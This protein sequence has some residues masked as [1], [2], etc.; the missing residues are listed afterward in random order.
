MKNQQ[1]KQLLDS[2]SLEE[3]I[4]QLVQLSG[5][6]YQAKSITTGPKQRLGITQKMVDLSGSVLNVTGAEQVK[7]VQEDHLKK[8]EH[9]IP[10]LFMADIV[11]GYRTIYPIPLGIGATWDFKLVEKAYCNTADE[12]S[13]SGADVTFAPMLDLVRD[14]RWGRVLESTGEDPVLNSCFARAMVKG[15]QKNLSNSNGLVACIKHFAGYGAVEAGREYNSVDLSLAN[16]KQ[17]YLPSYRSAVNAG[18]KMVMSSL[19]TLNGVPSTGDRWLLNDVL[20]KD[21]G[22]DGVII[23]DYA[24]IQELVNHGFASDNDDAARLAI[25]AGVDIDMK[26][27][28]YANGLSRLLDKGKINEEKINMAVWRVLRLKNDLGLFEDPFRGASAKRENNSLLSADKRSVARK[29]S[30]ESIV[31]LKNKDKVLPLSKSGKKKIAV[32]GPY[33]D[34]KDLIGLWALHA[35]SNDT[36]TLADGI[37]EKLSNSNYTIAK[38]TDILRDR[39]L[40]EK[41]GTPEESTKQLI[42]D[43]TSE[44]KQ[45][46]KALSDASKSDI[47]IFACGEHPIQS[48]EAGSRAL[49]RLPINQIKLFNKLIK[50]GKPIITIIFSGRPLVLTDIVSKSDGVLQAWFPG[51]EG[52]HALGDILFGDYNPSGH[53]SMGIPYIEGQLP[54]HYDHLSTGRAEETSSHHSRFVS[55]YID[56]PTQPLFPFGFGLSYGKMLYEKLEVEQSKVQLKQSVNCRVTLNNIGDWA[57]DEVVQIYFHDDVAS[58]V[59]P[60]KRL[61]DFKRVHVKSGEKIQVHFSIPIEKFG[62]YNREG[63]YKLEPGVFTL[64]AGSDSSTKLSEKFELI[65]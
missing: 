11:Y 46:Q 23:S 13:S 20:R 21:W 33:A 55:R 48:S 28:C 47:I 7:R 49:L 64:F 42:S 17:N 19:T 2:L 29:L 60:V 15:L 6:F 25:N 3:K 24:S 8:G 45:Q 62:F 34:N 63:N 36:V 61:I 26:S 32:I 30:R 40:F 1:L 31:L 59:Q 52:G 9:P 44:I 4:G 41:F 35:N 51:T 39:K 56:V 65:I 12:A 50:L 22:F 43:D 57:R 58:V 14:P 54:M 37:S 10:L 53:L 18:A 5:E 38:G 16:L 27:P